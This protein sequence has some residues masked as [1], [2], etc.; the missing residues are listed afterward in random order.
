MSPQ[1]AQHLKIVILP[2]L[3]IVAATVY[4]GFSRSA[5]GTRLPFRS[6]DVVQVSGTK[7]AEMVAISSDA[8]RLAYVME[9][10]GRQSLWVRTL[11]DGAQP[12]RLLAAANVQFRALTFSPDN[13]F[14]YYSHTDPAKGPEADYYILYRVPVN[15]GQPQRLINDIDTNVTFSQDGTR[16]LFL[17]ANDPE[18]GTSNVIEASVDGGN[19]K[20]IQS[21]PNRESIKELA[22]SPDG[23]SIA[24]V[25]FFQTGWLGMLSVRD[26]SSGKTQTVFKTED[27]MLNELAWLPSGEALALIYRSKENGLTLGQ[28]GLVTYPDGKFQRVT[29]DMNEG[30]AVSVSERIQRMPVESS[31]YQSISI[32]RDGKTMASVLLQLDGKVYVADRQGDSYGNARRVGAGEANWGAAWLDNRRLVLSRYTNLLTISADGGEPSNLYSAGSVV[33]NPVMCSKAGYIAMVHSV[34][35]REIGI[36]K[37]DVDGSNP[38][39]LTQGVN[40]IVPACSPDG[41]WLLYVDATTSSIMKMPAHGGEASK[42]ADVFWQ[43]G[44]FPEFSPDG[45]LLVAGSYDF[46]NPE[47]I[48][49]LIDFEQNRVVRTLHYHPAH[50]GNRLA[51][52]EDGKAIVYVV[53]ENGVDNL[54]LHPL[55]GS[56]GRLIT[57]FDSM[58]ILNFEFSPDWNRLLLTRGELP[59]QVVLLRDRT[60]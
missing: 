40:D 60:N 12:I 8:R 59:T 33:R 49:A 32:S 4:L 39:R 37:V 23:R 56:P 31:S 34:G 42:V 55:D 54:W 48:L 50:T 29:A 43:R 19:E 5:T 20:I 51:F 1:K 2:A 52:T 46:Q 47:P 18:P 14:V 25:P 13:S 58:Q 38:K 27:H 36:W 6:F 3:L 35:G 15:G 7:N 17:R 41:K 53:R 22:W 10:S 28:I 11:E 57:H 9:E 26:V 44:G 30:S 45:K 21:A 24:E 16:I